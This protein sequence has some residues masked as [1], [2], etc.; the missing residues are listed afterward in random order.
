MLAF[1]DIYFRIILS[2][3]VVIAVMLTLQ[4]G[5]NKLKLRALIAEAMASE[6]QVF[7]S[8][9]ENTITRSER[10]GL[11]MSESAGATELLDRLLEQNPNI[12]QILV[13]SPNGEAVLS[14]G[15][16]LLEAVYRNELL[17]RVFSG[18]DKVTMLDVGPL[19]YIGRT[20]LDSANA[21]MGAV[22]VT[23]PTTKLIGQA[24]QIF[25]SLVNKYNLLFAVIAAGLCPFI[26]IQFAGVGR[27]YK[28][29]DP[30]DRQGG[31][32]LQSNKNPELARLQTLLDEG[33]TAFATAETGLALL[34]ADYKTCSVKT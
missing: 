33:N 13:V 11:A 23:V 17:R 26:I 28:A 20:M 9:I 1:R 6:L 16:P 30:F 12:H 32:Q 4:V 5:L 2:I 24:E 15:H 21:V 31:H 25:A 27:A 3:L 7:A 8:T 19:L 18:R 14:S 10:L 22:I 29:L 34:E